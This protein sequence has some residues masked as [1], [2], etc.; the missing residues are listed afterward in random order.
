MEEAKLSYV[1]KSCEKEGG[2]AGHT[3]QDRGGRSVD[4]A[5]SGTAVGNEKGEGVVLKA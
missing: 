4:L 2:G 1:M 5:G 3:H